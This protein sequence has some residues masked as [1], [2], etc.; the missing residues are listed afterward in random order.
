MAIVKHT[1]AINMYTDFHNYV[2]F[3]DMLEL[4][5]ETSVGADIPARVLGMHLYFMSSQPF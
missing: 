3:A 5:A 4:D 1:A 2:K